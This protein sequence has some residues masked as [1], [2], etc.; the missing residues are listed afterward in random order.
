MN[1]FFLSRTDNL[2]N[3]LKK[4]VDEEI[5]KRNGRVAYISSEPQ[6][7][8]RPYYFSTIQDYTAIDESISVDYFDLSQS[9][10]DEDLNKL[11]EYNVIYLS[12]GNT[13]TFLDSANKRGL[14]EILKKILD[15]GGLLVGASAGSLMMTPTI[16]LAYS[17]DEN[18]VDL[19]DT[20]G[21]G[22]VSFEFHPHYTEGDN[23][24]LSKY[25]TNNKVYLCRDGDGIFVS[26]NEVK[27]FGDISEL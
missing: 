13:Y 17:Y 7:G 24:F 6:S 26:S 2:N 11:A 15:S 4:A 21:F 12:G 20:R 3:E 5:I 9:F 16:D 18:A 1:I 25:K 22:F 19:Q 23:D 14:K 8:D 27:M 10:S